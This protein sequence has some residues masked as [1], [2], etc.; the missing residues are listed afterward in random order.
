MP[1]A[2][3]GSYPMRVKWAAVLSGFLKYLFTVDGSVL[4]NPALGIAAERWVQFFAR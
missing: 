3:N 1:A 2:N 4:F